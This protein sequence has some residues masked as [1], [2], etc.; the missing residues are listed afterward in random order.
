MIVEFLEEAEAEVELFDA[1]LWVVS[2]LL[3][4]QNQR[5]FSRQFHRPKIQPF[6]GS[7]LFASLGCLAIRYS[8]FIFFVS[9]AFNSVSYQLS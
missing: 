2:G 4:S 8:S 6:C 5:N 1:A 3:P 9:S 7:W